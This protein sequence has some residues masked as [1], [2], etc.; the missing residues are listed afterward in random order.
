MDFSYKN[1]TITISSDKKEIILSPDSV[2]LDGLSIELPGE[3]EKSSILMYSFAKNDEQLYHFRTEGYWIA[4]IPEMLTD[5]STEALD[6]LGGIDILIMPGAKSMQPTL[7]K[8]EA[9]L[10]ITYGESAHEIALV[11]GCTGEIV[12]KYKL[13][14][15]DLSSEKTMCVVMG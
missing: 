8:V 13:K 3:Y 4:Y 14:D 7:E 1:S 6:F 2:I 12:S 9:G 5:I 15:A 11:L 10:L